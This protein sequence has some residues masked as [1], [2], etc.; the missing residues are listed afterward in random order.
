MTTREAKAYLAEGQFPPGSMEPKVDAAVQF[1]ESGGQDR[2][3][4]DR[5]RGGTASQ[6]T[7]T[8]GPPGWASRQ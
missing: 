7:E 5:N 4:E 8:R 6:G 1:I 3:P 2:S